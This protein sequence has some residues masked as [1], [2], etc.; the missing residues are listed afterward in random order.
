[1]KTGRTPLLLTTFISLMFCLSSA[2]AEYVAYAVEKNDKIPLPESI[3]DIDAKYLV[4]VQWGEYSGSKARVGVLEVE[5]ESKVETVSISGL[6]GTTSASV[7]SGGIPVQGIEAILTDVLH[8]SG[9]F[10]VLERT[11][12]DETMK[13]QDLGASGR[14]SKPSAAKIGKLLGAEYLIQGVVTNYEP[15]FKG[16]NIGLGGITRGLLG[17]VGI[18]SKKSMVGMNFRLVDAETGE[19]LFTKQVESVMSESGLSFGGAGWGGGGALGGFMSNYSKTPIGQAVIAA[20]NK[21]VF[22]LVK[23]VG[24]KPAS[25]KVIK[26]SSGKAYLNLN[27]S[28]VSVGDE[29]LVM[30]LGEELIDPDTGISLGS[31]SKTLG[32]LRIATAKEKFSIAKPVD[33]K[34]SEIKRGDKVVAAK[35]PEALAY[36][37]AWA[38][39]KPPK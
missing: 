38:K 24:A 30:S 34:I 22:E 36:G 6:F 33:V 15:D 25:G 31:E 5:N 2:K 23:E 18:K 10:R 26:V 39:G 1:M 21:G 11:K 27:D 29:V 8:R 16:K 3:D 4:D 17:G 7:N 9:R 35:K 28:Q 19:V 32:R 20:V 12:L 13:E 14:M 37:K